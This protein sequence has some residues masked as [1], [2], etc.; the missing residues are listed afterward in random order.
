LEIKS[1]GK[2]YKR[3]KKSFATVSLKAGH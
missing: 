2:C 1:V 3:I